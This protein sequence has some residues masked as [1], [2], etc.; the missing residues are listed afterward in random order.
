MKHPVQWLTAAPVWNAARASA[1]AAER[2]RRPVL[3]RFA[4]D[5]FMEDLLRALAEEPASLAGRVARPETWEEP[6]VG[7]VADDD[8]SPGRLLKLFQ[9]AHGRFYLAAASLVCRRPG[10]PCR[11][12]DT[13][14]GDR[15]SMVLRRLVP[16]DGETLDLDNPVTFDEQAWVGDREKGRWQTVERTPGQPADGGRVLDG[17]ERLPLFALGFELQGKARCLHAGLIP[18]GGRELYEGSAPTGNPPAPPGR[19]TIP[20]PPWRTRARRRGR[21]AQARPSACSPASR[22]PTTR[23][24][25]RRRPRWPAICCRSPCSTSPTCSASSSPPSGGPSNSVP[26]AVCRRRTRRSTTGSPRRLPGA[27]T[28]R[29]GAPPCSP[30]TPT[31]K[32]CWA[33]STNPPPAATPPVPSSASVAILRSAARG[34]DGTALDPDRPS[35]LTLDLFDALGAPA[36]GPLTPGTPDAAARA[37]AAGGAEGGL[38][39]LRFVYEKPRCEPL[40]VP[41]VSAPSRPFR[42]AS[43]FDPEAPARPVQIRLPLDTSVSGLRKFPKAVSLLLSNKLRQQVER[44]QGAGLGDLDSGDLGTAEPSLS[45]GMI[46]TLSIPIITICALIVLMIF[47][48]LLN[49]VFWWLPLFKICLPIPVRSDG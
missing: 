48:Q 28:R 7:W 47:V 31:A 16:V 37:A 33:T 45:L 5:T 25:K 4:G 43:F 10:L 21:R 34:L 9:P 27:V 19:R 18:V 44:V 14:A 11:K 35:A 42:L 22:S 20:S 8:P 23:W 15:A 24:S 38:Y 49:I 41:V 39:R 6:A 30:P 32:C 12:P 13:A 2:F 46:C 36:A 1:A 3:L 40:D 29:P 17:E 26:G